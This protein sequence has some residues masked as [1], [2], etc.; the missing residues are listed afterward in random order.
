MKGS[1]VP[2]CIK[3]METEA[4]IAG[5]AFVHYTAWL[6]TYPDLMPR[7]YLERRSLEKCEALTRA[8][9]ENTLVAL[10]DGRVV[11]FLGYCPEARDFVTLHPASEITGLYVLGAQQGKG[12]GAALLDRAL[13]LLPEKRVALFVLRGNENAIGF[14][15]H[16]GFRFTGASL[17]QTV[18]GGEL[19]ELE[20]VLER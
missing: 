1:A 18:P 12:V 4:E 5:K 10:A 13:E 11:G 16:K 7:E 15:R 9:P 2:Y 19:T 20:M 17:T 6:E 3:S 14:Y 8:F